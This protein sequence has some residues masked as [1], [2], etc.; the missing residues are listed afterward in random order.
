MS[1]MRISSVTE[2][3][4][5]RDRVRRVSRAVAARRRLDRAGDRRRRARGAGRVWVNGRE[6]GGTDPRFAHLAH[7]FD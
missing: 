4:D 6:L 3:G 7:S 5:R 2:I 1:N